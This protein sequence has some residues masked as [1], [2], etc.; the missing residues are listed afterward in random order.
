MAFL[1]CPENG[2]RIKEED[3]PADAI[4]KLAESNPRRIA[5][6]VRRCGPRKGKTT[7]RGVYKFLSPVSSPGFAQNLRP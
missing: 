7:N 2:H 6:A 5:R 1:D 3:S 4:A